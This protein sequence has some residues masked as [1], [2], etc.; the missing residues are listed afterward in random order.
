MALNN[1]VKKLSTSADGR[2]K[3]ANRQR[4]RWWLLLC[5]LLIIVSVRGWNLPQIVRAHSRATAASTQSAPQTTMGTTPQAAIQT[6]AMAAVTTTATA[7]AI[8]SVRTGAT[9]ETIDLAPVTDAGE[10]RALLSA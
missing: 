3:N 8:G 9:G 4:R 1:E 7:A 6:N 2:V 10:L 5:T